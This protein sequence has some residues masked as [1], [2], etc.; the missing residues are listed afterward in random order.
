LTACFFS[1]FLYSK[2]EPFPSGSLAS[3]LAAKCYKAVSNPRWSLA[4]AW[5][6][7]ASESWVISADACNGSYK[8]ITSADLQPKVSVVDVVNDSFSKRLV[9][10]RGD[11]WMRFYTCQQKKN[12]EQTNL[13]HPC[14]EK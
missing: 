7:R 8:D 11:G 5:M 2:K 6:H 9:K 13:E 10:C 3:Q 14:Y 4:A 1:L 12:E